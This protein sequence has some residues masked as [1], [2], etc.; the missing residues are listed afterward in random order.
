MG[1][2][3]KTHPSGISWEF[4][5]ELT[6]AG[7]C[8]GVTSRQ[9]GVS[10]GRYESLNLSLQV[11]DDVFCVL[12][13]RR[14]L[15]QAAGMDLLR[16]T[17]PAQDGSNH[18][19]VVGRA[20][21]GSGAGSSRTA[22]AHSSAVM[23]DIPGIPLMV[24]IADSVPVIIWD[25]RRRAC[26]VIHAGCASTLGQVAVKTVLAMTF[27]YGTQ[28]GDLMAFIGPS[29]SAPFLEISE[30]TARMAEKMGD[31]YRTCVQR[32]LKRTLD[33]RQIQYR[34]LRQAGLCAQRVF[35]SPSCVFSD[36]ARF[37]SYR[38]DAGH[39]GRM[40]AFAVIPP[41]AVP[42]SCADR[43]NFINSTSIYTL[44]SI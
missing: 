29:V 5:P 44:N 36:A 2:K 23:T 12:E 6:A 11:G 26:A 22:L 18:V 25:P 14:R 34:Q 8:H 27:V 20:E 1:T 37:F 13:N 41:Q 40:A 3:W 15:C 39:T 42:S 38:R 7:L 43:E 19:T 32:G 24:C 16:L 30:Q 35:V 9:G 33:L 28:P 21:Q 10:R 4:S 31:A 17:V